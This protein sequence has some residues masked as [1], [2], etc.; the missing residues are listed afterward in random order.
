MGH[1]S[2]GTS[3]GHRA[4]RGSAAP[5]YARTRFSL[6]TISSAASTA[7]LP[8]RSGTIS[9]SRTPST[10]PSPTRTGRMLWRSAAAT[11][12]MSRAHGAVLRTSP[13]LVTIGPGHTHDDEFGPLTVEFLQKEV[14]V[15]TGDPVLVPIIV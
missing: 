13:W 15:R 2:T 4:T 6:A 9:F 8:R 10:S 7:G 12:C 5:A 3:R 11:V 1:C 14:G